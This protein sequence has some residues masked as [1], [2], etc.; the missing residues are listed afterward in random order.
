MLWAERLGALERGSLQGAPVLSLPRYALCRREQFPFV[1]AFRSED[2][3]GFLLSKQAT[4]E[5]ALRSCLEK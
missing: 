1:G 2:A 5:G 3:S 4:L